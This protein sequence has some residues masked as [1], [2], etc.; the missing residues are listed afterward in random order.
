MKFNILIIVLI[1][2]NTKTM[3][4]LDI[5]KSTSDF[6]GIKEDEQK[7]LELN[8][9]NT[10]LQRSSCHTNMKINTEILISL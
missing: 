5:K 2:D 4:A 6:F 9:I 7:Y 1:F 10:Y 8:Q 3:L